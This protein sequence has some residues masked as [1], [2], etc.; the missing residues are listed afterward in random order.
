MSRQ[1]L[2]AADARMRAS[3]GEHGVQGSRL[4]R[5]ANRRRRAW[6]S[7][8]RSP[9]GRHP[10]ASKAR[11]MA[12]ASPR[13]SDPSSQCWSRQR[14]GPTPTLPRR[15]RTSQ[16]AVSASSA[17]GRP[18]RR[19]DKPVTIRDRTTRAPPD[20]DS[21]TRLHAME[22]IKRLHVEVFAP[23]H[24]DAAQAPDRSHRGHS[25]APA[26]S[27]RRPTQSR[28]PPHGSECAARLKFKLPAIC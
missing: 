17:A 16:A 12:A 7:R 6:H 19:S 11:R 5:V 10:L 3:L 24:Q 21:A 25:R 8:N 20:P 28:R 27:K 1:R 2:G 15:W 26:S 18:R 9:P 22:S 13:P 23:D 4:G 14:T